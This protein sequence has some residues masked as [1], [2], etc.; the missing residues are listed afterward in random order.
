MF[1]IILFACFIPIPIIMYFF[2]LNEVKPKKNLILGVTLPNYARQ[3]DSVK[4]LCAGYKKLLTADTVF[5][6]LLAAPVIFLKYDSVSFTYLMAWLIFAIVLPA[7]PYAIYN[8][9]LKSLKTSKNWF[10]EAAGLSLVDV[11]VAAMPKRKLNIWLFVVPIVIGF[12]PVIHTVAA[13]RGKDEFWPMFIVYALDAAVIVLFYLLYRLIYHQKAEV[14]DENT[15]LSAALTQV[16]LY[17]WGK[18]WIWSAWLTGIYNLVL[19]ML[20]KKPVY[21]LISSAVYCVIL[22]AVSMRV[23]FR[24]RKVQQ[25]LTAD[26]GKTIYTDED[27]KW[28]LGMFYYNPNDSHFMVNKRIGTGMTINI[29]RPSGKIFMVIVA[30]ILLAM[31]LFGVGMMKDEFTPVKLGANN[32]QIVASHTSDVY[33]ISYSDIESAEM[34]DALPSCTRTNGTGMDTVLK[35]SFEADGIGPCRFCL[36][37]RT[38][39]FIEIKTADMTYILGSADKKETFAAYKNLTNAGIKA[40]KQQ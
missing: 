21:L 37:P 3:D 34:I 19:W 11:K 13:L 25:N 28:F 30:V 40:G 33:K 18:F 12:I 20:I 1:R 4:S 15:S 29:G 27:D 32:T 35:G 14:I 36:D 26:S 16:R 17:N 9:K 8:K 2:L 7:V 31:P 39:P 24:T 38:P 6:I 5:V 10:G 23:E 22:V